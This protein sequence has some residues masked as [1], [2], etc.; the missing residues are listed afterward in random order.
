[1]VFRGQERTIEQDE[2]PAGDRGRA[3]VAVDERRVAG[4]AEGQARGKVGQVGRRVLMG[5][6][7]LRTG[8]PLRPR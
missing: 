8:Q 2:D 7:L 5:M 4:Q 3:L 1:M 6:K